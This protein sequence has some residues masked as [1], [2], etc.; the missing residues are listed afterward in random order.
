VKQ[1]EIQYEYFSSGKIKK[2]LFYGST[3]ATLITT[4]L[5]NEQG[6]V[7][8]INEIT[9]SFAKME[10]DSQNRLIKRI[11]Y[12]ADTKK[13]TEDTY[14][15]NTKNLITKLLRT[16]NGVPYFTVVKE[17]DSKDR[18]LNELWYG[19][20]TNNITQ[21]YTYVYNGESYRKSYLG[22]DNTLYSYE[23]NDITGGLLR[24]KSNYNKIGLIKTETYE[25]DSYNNLIKKETLAPPNIK[26]LREEWVYQCP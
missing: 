26:P 12:K 3:T 8:Q 17:Y 7:I 16:E 19:G 1:T 21:K 4:T 13:T 25:Y 23:D 6:S 24:K 5:Y 15:Y 2:M 10:Y 11:D 9:G 20:N 14:Q 18:I 22:S